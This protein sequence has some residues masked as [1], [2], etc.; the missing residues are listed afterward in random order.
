[1]KTY[2]KQSLIQ[3]LR[4]VA[5]QGWISSAR[6]GNQ[7]GIGNTLEDLLGIVENNLPIPN[8]AEWE[9]KTQRTGT[10]SL[11]TLFHS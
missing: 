1:M 3:R 4:E 11:I 8:A 5:D 10:T 2:T 7:G 6:A 9:L